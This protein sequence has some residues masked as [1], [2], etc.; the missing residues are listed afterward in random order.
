MKS[1]E[2]RFVARNESSEFDK[3]YLNE[4][5]FLV[6][7]HWFWPQYVDNWEPDTWAFFDQ[8]VDAGRPVVDIGSWIGPTV[9]FAAACGAK[10]IVAVEGNPRTAEHLALT[11]S[12]ND[13]LIGLEIINRVIAPSEGLVTFGNLD[14]SEATS[15]ASSTRGT[16][17]NVPSSTISG[18]IDRFE[19]HNASIIKIDI[20]GS[21]VLIADQLAALSRSNAAILLSLHPPFWKDIANL[22]LVHGFLQALSLFRIYSVKGNELS[23]EDVEGMCRYAGDVPPTW[24]TPFGNFFEIV[25]CA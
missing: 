13:K 7:P 6:A 17:F 19:C 20:E 23:V 5:E 15:S 9:L 4:A 14:G 16:G 8:Y 3:I 12:A 2:R 1:L 25:L 22:E 11:R 18:V 10:R 24:G 21:E